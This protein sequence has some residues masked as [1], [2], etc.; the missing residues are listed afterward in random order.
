MNWAGTGD[1]PPPDPLQSK[2]AIRILR[3]LPV[4][5]GSLIKI[6]LSLRLGLH[7]LHEKVETSNGGRVS[8]FKTGPI[9]SKVPIHKR[10][11]LLSTYIYHYTELL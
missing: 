10:A 8:S 11:N 3:N 5:N 2:T 9:P 4:S 6:S 1:L 7:Q